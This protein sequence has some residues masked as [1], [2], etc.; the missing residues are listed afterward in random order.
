MYQKIQPFEN[1]G[2]A[3]SLP[4]TYQI[5]ILTSLD[6]KR[7]LDVGPRFYPGADVTLRTWPVTRW[8]RTQTRQERYEPV[9]ETT[10]PT[11]GGQVGVLGVNSTSNLDD[12]NV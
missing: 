11:P 9:G 6:K 4:R 12:L 3:V 10:P 7:Y 2:S 5:E 8:S 1:Q